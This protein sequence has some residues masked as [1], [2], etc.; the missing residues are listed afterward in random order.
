MVGLLDHPMLKLT[1]LIFCVSGLGGVVVDADHLAH[2][3]TN[4]AEFWK[5]LDGSWL[6]DLNEMLWGKYYGRPLHIPMA[7]AG[8][9]LAGYGFACFGRFV[10]ARLL[11]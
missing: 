10:K 7:A 6:G 1:L 11:E 3:F 5:P 8:V 4:P 2:V 9:L